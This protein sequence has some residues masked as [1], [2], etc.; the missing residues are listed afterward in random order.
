LGYWA[1]AAS[2]R[3]PAINHQQRAIQPINFLQ[4]I[5]D[6]R[7][8]HKIEF[9][10]NIDNRINQVLNHP[11]FINQLAPIDFSNANGIHE[12]AQLLL[13]LFIK[14]HDFTV[15]HGVTSCHAL[16]NVH[17]YYDDN[18]SL[19]LCYYWHALGATYVTIGTPSLDFDLSLNSELMTWELI[20]NKAIQS[21]DGH[22]IKFL[23]TCSKENEI[24]S[25]PFYQWA[26]TKQIQSPATF[27]QKPVFEQT[28]D[29]DVSLRTP[30]SR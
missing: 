10:G 16:R 29:E 4:K 13:S 25:N 22:V 5:R 11:D 6:T 14:T 24:Y 9:T 30:M 17:S 7:S 2:Y 23:Y 21:T 18:F 19:L 15:L 1:A 28:V 26:A 8:F 12:T 3:F 27:C 20:K